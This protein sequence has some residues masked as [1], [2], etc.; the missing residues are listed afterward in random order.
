MDIDLVRAIHF[1]AR[2]HS[3]QR[4]KDDAQT[5][6]INHPLEVMYLLA[7]VGR[8]TDERVLMG[9]VLHDTIEDTSTTHAELASEFGPDVAD[10]VREVTDDKT[11]SRAERKRLQVEKVAGKS[12]GA[13]L[14]KL[15]DKISNISDMIGNTPSAWPVERIVAYGQWARDVVDGL[16]GVN[17]A[18]ESRFDEAL[19]RL[20][21][22]YGK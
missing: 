22:T 5:P 19:E 11:L 1:A 8:I 6:Y 13:R 15:A 20:F 18:L 16:R 9:A 7:T 21:A 4:R 10:Y 17:A 2:K 3:S 12:T 14:I